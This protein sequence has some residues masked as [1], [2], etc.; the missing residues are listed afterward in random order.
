MRVLCLGIHGTWRARGVDTGEGVCSGATDKERRWLLDGYK[1][2]RPVR[3]LCFGASSCCSS[4]R[5]PARGRRVCSFAGVGFPWSLWSPVHEGTPVC[6]RVSS[7][8]ERDPWI[9]RA[10]AGRKPMQKK[11]LLL[12]FLKRGGR[13]RR[14]KRPRKTAIWLRL[15]SLAKL[16]SS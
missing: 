12:L 2:E 13:G 15:Y 4:D 1:K 3:C 7:E 9:S 11:E 5:G 16:Q 10:R 6:S 8:T 14:I